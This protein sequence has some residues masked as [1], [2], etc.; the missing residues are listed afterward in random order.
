[1][2]WGSGIK[3]ITG[4]TV[5]LFVSQII[6]QQITTGFYEEL[7][8]RFLILEGYFYGTKT[9]KSKLMY[10]FISFVLFGAVHVVN[11]WD[12]YTFLRTGV[13]GHAFAVMYLNTRN[14]L[15]PM[16]LHFLYDIA[17]NLTYYMEWKDST[18]HQNMNLLFDIM[19]FIMFTISL[20]M[21]LKRGNSDVS[22]R[23]LI[24][25][26]KQNE[27]SGKECGKV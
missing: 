22:G 4:L 15:I 27:I 24:N 17:A 13:I 6:L 19:L 7:N 20:I 10:S 5:G 11:G 23:L 14:I 8:Y 25:N 21:I 1:M 2:L 18:L 3:S 12:T 9:I 16:V 26:K